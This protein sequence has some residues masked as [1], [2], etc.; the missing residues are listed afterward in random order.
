MCLLYGLRMSF[1]GARKTS[2]D[3]FCFRDHAMPR[4]PESAFLLPAFEE[5]VPCFDGHHAQNE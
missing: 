3:E 4:A 1:R 2:I 5:G